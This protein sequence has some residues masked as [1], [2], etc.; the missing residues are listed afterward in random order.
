MSN[1]RA[2]APVD[3]AKL[4][5][6]A[7]V[8][9]SSFLCVE[10]ALTALSPLAIAAGRLLLGALA[11]FAVLRLFGLSLAIGRGDWL[12]CLGIGLLN[13]A[14]PFALISWGQQHTSSGRAAILIACAP[15][16]ALLLAHFFTRDDRFSAGKLLGVA[17]GFAG[18]LSLIGPDAL[19]GARGA[20]S[21]QLAVAAGALCY[22]SASVLT[23]RLSHLPALVSS[24]A[25][26]VGAAVLAPPILLYQSASLAQINAPALAAMLYMGLVPTALAYLLRV[27]LV[28]QVGTTFLA[29]VGY[30]IPLFAVFWGWLFLDERPAAGAW[31]ALGLIFAGLAASRWRRPQALPAQSSAPK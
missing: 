23:R 4:L 6:L 24:T 29:Q 5:L 1:L 2:P 8:W 11:M 18:V 15:F 14:L 17:L 13:S 20:V 27:Q 22:A 9:G 26:L 10:I 7:A 28:Q 21:G 30:L 19:R 12:C 16:F 31:L 25:M 3:Y